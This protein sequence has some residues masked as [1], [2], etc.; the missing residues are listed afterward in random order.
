M[1]DDVK[2]FSLADHKLA[3]VKN[4]FGEVLTFFCYDGWNTGNQTPQ[5]KNLWFVLKKM[6]FFM[7]FSQRL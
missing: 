3:A 4:G 2:W 1:V 7:G 6:D 5:L